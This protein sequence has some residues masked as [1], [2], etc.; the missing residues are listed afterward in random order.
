MLD[1][2]LVDLALNRWPTFIS[3][4]ISDSFLISDLLL[5]DGRAWNP[6]VVT[7]I[8]GDV[9]GTRVLSIALLVHTNHDVRVWRS[10]CIPRVV[11][12]DLYHL[13]H[14]EPP[15]SLDVGW[16]WRMGI[17]PRVSMFIW[18]VAWRRLPTRSFLIIR[19]VHLPSIYPSC[20]K[21]GEMLKHV[22]FL[23]LRAYQV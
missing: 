13:Y 14:K 10:S 6:V 21:G 12:S 17:H 2:W 1:L 4:D 20:G 11:M 18:K 5:L 19:G 22:I 9:L 7:C 3:T 23:Y 16:I 8:F 15:R